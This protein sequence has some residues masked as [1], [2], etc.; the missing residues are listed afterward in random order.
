MQ[1]EF[2]QRDK[3]NV[4]AAVEAKHA[5]PAISGFLS[6]LS[7]KSS[8]LYTQNKRAACCLNNLICWAQ[9][10]FPSRFSAETDSLK[11]RISQNISRKLRIVRNAARFFFSF[12]PKKYF[13]LPLVTRDV[14]WNSSWNYFKIILL[15]SP[16]SKINFV[17]APWRMN[18]ARPSV[19]A[20]RAS[21]RAPR[22]N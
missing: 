19:N 22:R 9:K 4:C 11:T 10:S 13:L 15:P 12:T 18:F 7:L 3:S 1:K 17:P 16:R 21:F 5:A 2:L 14:K 6:L 20:T 8:I